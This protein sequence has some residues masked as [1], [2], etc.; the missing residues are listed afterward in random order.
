MLKTRV[1]YLLF[2]ASAPVS[3]G[4]N[5]A[6]NLLDKILVYFPFLSNKIVLTFQHL[7]QYFAQWRQIRHLFYP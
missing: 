2:V 6:F 3:M 1:V 7:Q 4:L 5:S